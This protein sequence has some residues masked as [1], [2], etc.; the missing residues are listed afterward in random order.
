MTH[1]IN[2]NEMDP[3]T[4]CGLELDGSIALATI[5]ETPTCQNCIGDTNMTTNNT[6]D[7]GRMVQ[8]SARDGNS[9]FHHGIHNAD[10]LAWLGIHDLHDAYCWYNTNVHR[11]P[12]NAI[13]ILRV[14]Q[15]VFLSYVGLDGRWKAVNANTGRIKLLPNLRKSPISTNAYA[16]FLRDKALDIS[17][18]ADGV[19]CHSCGRIN[20]A[21][22]EFGG[23]CERCIST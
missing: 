4:E 6:I 15:T 10:H 9:V 13:R 23:M 22:P 16:R 7:A 20:G 18:S 2:N 12:H 21:R 1:R 11:V 5:H 17:N 19:N 8:L 14:A 3:K